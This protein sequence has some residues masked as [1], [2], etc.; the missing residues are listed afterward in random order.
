[1]STSQK[2][3]DFGDSKIPA[4]MPGDYGILCEIFSQILRI[5]LDRFWFFFERDC[6]DFWD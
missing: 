2:Y 6:A 3:E 4:N 1:M 5:F